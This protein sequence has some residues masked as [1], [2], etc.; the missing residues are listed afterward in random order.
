MPD[1]PEATALPEAIAD[2]VRCDTGNT[3]VVL[4]G[5]RRSVAKV[6]LHTWPD[7]ALESA[8]LACR[9]VPVGQQTVLISSRTPMAMTLE[10]SELEL[11]A[12][13]T[14]N[15]VTDRCLRQRWLGRSRW[16]VVSF[17]GRDVQAT[18]IVEEALAA[19]RDAASLAE[20]LSETRVDCPGL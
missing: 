8:T 6:V 18:V 13:F 19:L 2:V 11:S 1:G 7:A 14:F 5:W 3:V 16:R 15:R 10:V 20:P 9:L 4:S 17:E 12:E